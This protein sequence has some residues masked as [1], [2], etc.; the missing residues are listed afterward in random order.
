[1][2]ILRKFPSSCSCFYLKL[3][4]TASRFEKHSTCLRAAPNTN[5][6]ANAREQRRRHNRCELFSVGGASRRPIVD[7]DTKRHVGGLE[8]TLDFLAR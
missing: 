3:Y 5:K 4:R 2:K 7:F 1:M 6:T 8:P